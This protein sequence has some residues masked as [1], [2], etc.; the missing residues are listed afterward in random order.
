VFGSTN[1]DTSQ[2][3]KKKSIENMDLILKVFAVIELVLV[4]VHP[5]VHA[6][7]RDEFPPDFVFGASDSAYQVLYY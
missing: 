1:Q 5:S 2:G 7:S 3:R 4:I 6:L